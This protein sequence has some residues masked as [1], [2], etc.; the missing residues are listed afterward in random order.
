[1]NTPISPPRR[2]RL[3]LFQ[4]ILPLDRSRI[5][6]DL[7]A[8]VTLAAI[9]IPQAM[10]YTKIAGTPVITGLYT[11]LLPMVAFAVFGASRY[12]VVAADSATAAI[13]AVGVAPLAA[14]GSPRY[15]ALASTVALMAAGFLLLA[16]LLRLG[17]LSDF[18]SR[19]VLIGFLTGVG[20]QVGI[21][22]LG[23]MLGIAVKSHQ[24]LGQLE[25]VLTRLP[26]LHW[27]TLAVSAGVIALILATRRLAPR[28]PGSL[29]A[30]VGA[31]ALSAAGDFEG[32]GIE[33]IGPVVGGLP[34]LGLPSVSWKD[35][36][37][38]FSTAGACF[39][40]IVA[41]SSVTA[42]AYAV[43]HHQTLDDNQDL[44]GLCAADAAAGLSGTFV[45]N[46]SP[47]QTAMVEISGGGSQLAHLATAATVA[48]VLLCLT[49][50][51]KFLPI[52]VLGAIVFVVAI[53]L[54]DIKGLRTL[55][56]NSPGEFKLAMVTTAA[57]VVLGVERGI[58]LALVLSLIQHLRH[59]YRPHTAIVMRDPAEHWC[60]VPVAP[61]RMLEPGLVMYWFG[62]DLYYANVNRFVEQ[63]HLIVY[64]SPSPVRWLAVDT[65][66]IT[67]IDF[68]AAR[69]LIDLQQD[70]AQRG[71]TLVFTRVNDGLRAE[72]DRQELTG[73]VGASHIFGSRSQCVVAYQAA[74]SP[75]TSRPSA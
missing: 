23:E 58:L 19:T 53:G 39:I 74:S 44:L 50:P 60:M 45:V 32:R 5:L 1:M 65:G 40:M 62:A 38:L 48:V 29:F 36:D 24:T 52:C 67:G 61:G 20:F 64:E 55:R 49:G 54:V 57:V 12:L 33:V 59:S 17:F 69:A 63:A 25:T 66:A 4:G 28:L 46:G 9:N 10:G 6:P 27:P 7:M 11:L 21:S 71:V 47:T 16:R 31:I 68:S 75:A 37:V 14:A 18:L 26:H 43:R 51:L 3:P 15:L 42:R 22:V 41:Q 72:M 13:L 30:A 73:V 2:W 70:L 35:V 34:N 8:G 56:R